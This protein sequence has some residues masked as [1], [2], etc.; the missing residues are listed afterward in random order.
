MQNRA[1]PRLGCIVF[2]CTLGGREV[3]SCPLKGHKIQPTTGPKKAKLYYPLSKEH[4]NRYSTNALRGEIFKFIWLKE[5][6]QWR[7]MKYG[8]NIKKETTNSMNTYG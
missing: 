6:S 1:H 2:S 3:V 5:F 8:R 4:R 7:E